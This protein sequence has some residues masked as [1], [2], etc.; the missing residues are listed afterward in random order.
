MVLYGYHAYRTMNEFTRVDASHSDMPSCHGRHWRALPAGWEVA[1][2]TK[3]VR[4]N[5]VTPHTW[6]THLMVLFDENGLDSFYPAYRTAGFPPA[7]EKFGNTQAKA[8]SRTNDA[9]FRNFTEYRCPWDCYQILIRRPIRGRQEN[10]SV[11][12]SNFWVFDDAE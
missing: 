3:D 2:D 10:D 7:G 1:P 11:E 6:G 5:V 8:Q 9:H 4:D 12:P